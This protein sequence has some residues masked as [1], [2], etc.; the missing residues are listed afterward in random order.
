MRLHV[1]Q[2]V[3]ARRPSSVRVKLQ[4]GLSTW[5]YLRTRSSMGANASFLKYAQALLVHTVTAILVRF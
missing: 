3:N 2:W 1:S 4:N 5:V